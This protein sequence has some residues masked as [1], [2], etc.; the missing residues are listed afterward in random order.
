MGRLV[1]WPL[2]LGVASMEPLSGPRAVG[3]ATTTSIGS[4]TQT[5]ASPFGIWRWQFSF[6]PMYRAKFRRYRGWIT[7]LHG[8]ANATRVPFFDPDKMAPAEIGLAAPIGWTLG[9]G[10][11]WYN[12][13]PWFNGHDWSFTPP[14]VPVAAAA[15]AR[16]TT[17]HV[18][19]EFW[20]HSL[21]VGDYLGFLPFHLGLY[22]VTE[23]FEPGHYRIW[24]PLRRAIAADDFATLEPNLA[25]RLEGEQAAT[26]GRGLSASEGAVVT[27][28]EVEDADVRDYFVD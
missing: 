10:A 1:D 5:T 4:F 23:V 12:G 20:G 2:G 27:L 26:A 16:D 22:I 18:A 7:S 19:D 6:P 24:P 8:G 17:V 14:T 15:S 9:Q 25:M 21:D 11:P 28:V 3:A 13:Q